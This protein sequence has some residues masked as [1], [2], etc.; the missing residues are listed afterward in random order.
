METEPQDRDNTWTR[1][2]VT[3][4]TCNITLSTQHTARSTRR[5]NNTTRMHRTPNDPT[6]AAFLGAKP[7]RGQTTSSIRD[8][9][10]S[11]R[12]LNRLQD[13]LRQ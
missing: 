3:I 10:D 11:I 6:H 5:L 4:W 13:S 1:C 12:L 8:T 2:G 7:T 9:R